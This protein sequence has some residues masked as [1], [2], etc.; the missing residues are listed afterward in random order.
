MATLFVDGLHFSFP[1]N[2]AAEKY[3]EW[4]HYRTQLM[5]SGLA[6]VD[7]VAYLISSKAK[8]AWLIEAKDFRVQRGEQHKTRAGLPE[9]MAKKVRD[10]L[11]GLRDAAAK[12]VAL[13]EQSC[14]AQ[15]VAR[16]ARV[17]LHLEPFNPKTPSKL[18]PHNPS[19]VLQKLKQ[20]LADIDPHPL[21]LS[22]ATT[23]SAR[24]PWTVS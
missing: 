17:V 23:P 8:I 19:L 6:A 18:Y 20:L 7:I 9:H 14:A 24:V 12:A 10:T 3:D 13:P 2:F 15:A 11:A 16:T 4:Q 1:P 5:P 21:V 22:I